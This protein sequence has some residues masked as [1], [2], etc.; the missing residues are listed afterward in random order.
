LSVCLP[1]TLDAAEFRSVPD[2]RYLDLSRNYISRLPADLGIRLTQL[3]TL[4]LSV[5]A[6]TQLSASAFSGAR[7]L[8]VLDVSHNRIQ[9]R[10]MSNNFLPRDAIQS[11]V[12]L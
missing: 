3:S 1:G 6:L 10:N 8:S 12:V 9:V 2:L 7:R 5:N 11:A 4:N